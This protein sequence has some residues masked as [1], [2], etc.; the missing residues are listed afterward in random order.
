MR[1]CLLLS[2]E[3]HRSGGDCGQTEV[4]SWTELCREPKAILLVDA[5]F[6]ER[7]GI[8]EAECCSSLEDISV[9]GCREGLKVVIHHERK[10]FGVLVQD[11][12][13]HRD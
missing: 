10:A 11:E 12:G 13:V 3:P 9:L 4:C 8:E 2:G 6:R 5:P 7:N 1:R